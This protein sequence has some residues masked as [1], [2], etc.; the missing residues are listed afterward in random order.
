MNRKYAR[1]NGTNALVT[2][3]KKG[4]DEISIDMKSDVSQVTN[5][6]QGDIMFA[7]N[8]KPPPAFTL[9][10]KRAASD[11]TISSSK[12]LNTDPSSVLCANKMLDPH[13]E[14]YEDVQANSRDDDSTN[15]KGQSHEFSY[16]AKYKSQFINL[17]G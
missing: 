11:A 17:N 4:D 14:E 1:R 12:N 5:A 8:G 15:I 6:S 7:G 3:T 2:Q 10:K 13:P 16:E 9:P